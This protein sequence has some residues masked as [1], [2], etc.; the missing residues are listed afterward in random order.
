MAVIPKLLGIS[1]GDHGCGRTLTWIVQGAV[2]GGLRALILREPHLSEAAYVELARRLSP[3]LGPGLILH[4][5]HPNAAHLAGRAGWGLHLPAQADWTGVRTQIKGLLGASCHNA[6]E[7]AAAVDA[8]VDYA[9]ISP[10]FTPI[11]KPADVRPSLGLEELEGLANSVGIPVFALG[12]MN[13]ENTRS[14]LQSGA[15][16]VASMGFLFPPD[17][18]ADVST[19]NASILTKLLG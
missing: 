10:V 18:D 11:S 15:H 2:D 8:G 4:G 9:T 12:G 14:V 16:G 13:P 3:L 1:P 5:S 19:E 6:D 7:L 17:A